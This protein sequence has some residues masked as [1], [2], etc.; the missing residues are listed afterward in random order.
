[1]VL[2]SLT[3]PKWKEQFGRVLIEAQA[4]AVPVVGSDSGAIPEVIGKAGLIYPEGNVV[5]LAAKLRQL[6]NSKTLRKKLIQMGRKQV[7]GLYTNQIIAD[8]LFKIYTAILRS[9]R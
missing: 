3:T 1:L 7:L 5:Q 2:P 6:K 9:N 8:K 4:C